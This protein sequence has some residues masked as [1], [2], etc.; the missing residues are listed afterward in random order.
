[1]SDVTPRLFDPAAGDRD[2]LVPGVYAAVV[3]CLVVGVALLG[4]PIGDALYGGLL[5]WLLVAT[6][7]PVSAINGA[8]GGGLLESAAIGAVPVVAFALA[9][10]EAL[11]AGT[12]G[13][14][15]AVCLGGAL[16][17]FVAG[18]AVRELSRLYY[19]G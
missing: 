4:G 13:R 10:R 19:E 8:R 18:Y 2:W 3:L 12:L 7:P 17:G 5:P 15:A 11:A 14:V 1:M 16:L 6:P 9:G